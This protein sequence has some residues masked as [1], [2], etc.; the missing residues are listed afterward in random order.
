M[1]KKLTHKEKVRVLG[2]LYKPT[3]RVLILIGIATLLLAC[4]T[5]WQH[6]SLVRR[7][8]ST[9]GKV[10]KVSKV[11]GVGKDER[12][13]NAQKCQV[14]YEITV[15]G[16]TYTDAMA[17]H[18]SPTVDKCNLKLGQAI[19]VDYDKHRPSNSSYHLDTVNSKHR[20]LSDVLQSAIG[21]AI[22]GIIPIVIGATGLRVAKRDV[23][24]NELSDEIVTKIEKIN[25]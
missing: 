25:H 12:G 19:D 24:P 16:R 4:T 20:T 10:T 3:C 7:T 2:Q 13:Q 22:V 9:K 1:R 11:T 14:N 6:Y 21:I 18:G 17:Y 8:I 15:D 23:D 5:A